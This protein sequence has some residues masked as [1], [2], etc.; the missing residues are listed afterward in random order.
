LE[1]PSGSQVDSLSLVATGS[2]RHWAGAATVSL[3]RATIGPHGS[4]E[5]EVVWHVWSR[6]DPWESV[7]AH[8]IETAQAPIGDGC[9]VEEVQSMMGMTDELSLA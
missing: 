5:R 2:K 3:S 4:L 9:Y 7:L 1:C 6:S 8:A